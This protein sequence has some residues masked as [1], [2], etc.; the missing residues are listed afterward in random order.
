[1]R[2]NRAARRHGVGR[3]GSIPAHAGEPESRECAVEAAAAIAVSATGTIP[4]LGFVHEDPGQSFVLDIADLYRDTVTVPWAFRSAKSVAEHP[5]ANVERVTRRLLGQALAREQ[6]IPAMI[7]KDQGSV[8]RRF[9][10]GVAPCRSPW[11]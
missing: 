2:G 8:C 6:V 9:L 3:V 7:D 5:D 1:M 11:W 10:A 4:Q